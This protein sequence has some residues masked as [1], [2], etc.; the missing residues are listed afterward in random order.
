VPALFSELA[1]P[2][3]NQIG[4]QSYIVV[5]VTCVTGLV[6]TFVWWRSADQAR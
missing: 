5:G 2:R 6:G 1:G 4:L 3:A